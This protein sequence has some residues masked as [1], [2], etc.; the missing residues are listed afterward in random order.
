[1]ASTNASAASAVSKARAVNRR[2]TSRPA[3]RRGQDHD[4]ENPR[5]AREEAVPGSG[6]AS[7]RD[8]RPDSLLTWIGRS[9]APGA[10]SDRRRPTRAAPGGR[11]SRHTSPRRRTTS[12]N[13]QG[14]SRSMLREVL[15]IDRAPL[16][17]Q[18]HVGS[19]R[20]PVTVPLLVGEA[21]DLEHLPVVGRGGH[22]RPLRRYQI[23]VVAVLSVKATVGGGY[24]AASRTTSTSLQVSGEVA[25][26]SP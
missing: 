10:R 17:L 4:L 12:L 14:S 24:G 22:H 1:M 15:G 7:R 16:H 6:V 11:V 26:V 8:T 19:V 21:G 9:S 25:L 3:Q 20:R 23:H 18:R 5:R 2:P 13:G